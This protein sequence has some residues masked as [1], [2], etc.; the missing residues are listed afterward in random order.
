MVRKYRPKPNVM[1]SLC[2]Y[3]LV[4][5]AIA[6]GLC[7][8]LLGNKNVPVMIGTSVLAV[9]VLTFWVLALGEHFMFSFGKSRYLTRT[10]RK[11]LRHQRKKK[12]GGENILGREIPERDKR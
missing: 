9:F 8:T 4:L 1:K 6:L 11:R 2:N 12:A 10:E 5:L 7:G 3:L